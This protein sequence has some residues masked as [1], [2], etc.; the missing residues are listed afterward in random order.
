MQRCFEK[1]G[2]EGKR[3]TTSVFILF[4]VFLLWWEGGGV[5]GEVKKL[6][7]FSRVEKV[8]RITALRL[9]KRGFKGVNEQESPFRHTTEP[10]TQLTSAH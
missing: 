7:G 1:I 10:E 4:C 6:E 3:S 2:F 5:G 9:E 8:D